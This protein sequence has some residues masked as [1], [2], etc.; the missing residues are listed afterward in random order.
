MRASMRPLRLLRFF[1]LL[2]LAACASIPVPVPGQFAA[3][4]AMPKGLPELAP[5]VLIGERT[6]RPLLFGMSTLS[7][8]TW[9]QV[10]A[11]IVIR[12]PKGVIVIDAPFSKATARDLGREPLS[13][14]L[15]FG[16]ARTKKA[17]APLLA[18]AGI[19]PRSVTWALITHAHW[20][21]TGGLRELP[22]A[23]VLLSER[24]VEW[25]RSMPEASPILMLWNLQGAASRIAPFKF[26]GGPYEGFAESHDVLGDGSIVAVPLP[27]HTPGSTGY[28]VN[29]GTG[30]RW[31]FAGDASWTM[32]G[33]RRPALKNPLLRAIVDEDE[34]ATARTLGLLHA[35]SK[36]RPDI[37]IVPSHDLDGMVGIPPCA[38][39][40]SANGTAETPKG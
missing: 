32:E 6:N 30:R 36:D 4:V 2:Q 18:A 29:S 21:H 1:A 20:D 11:A 16:D 19:E 33:I 14:R 38:A 22:F 37:V 24:E 25:T 5:C 3:H 39:R 17:T 26:D 9:H 12:H 28:F 8:A 31:L 23:Q 10:I 13:F 40:A 27:G 7:F 15:A 35:L 34:E